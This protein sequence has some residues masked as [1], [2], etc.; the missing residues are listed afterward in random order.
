MRAN[1]KQAL[2]S[3]IRKGCNCKKNYC[4]KNYCICHAAG[5]KCDPDLCNCTDCYNFDGAPDPPGKKSLEAKEAC[6]SRCK[7]RKA[8]NNDQVAAFNKGLA[9]MNE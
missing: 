5:L 7:K 9:K 1:Q 8:A 6:A 2:E 3:A 4:K